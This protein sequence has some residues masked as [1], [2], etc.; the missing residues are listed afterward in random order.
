MSRKIKLHTFNALF[1]LF[2]HLADRTG[3]WR[4]FVRPKLL[5]GSLIVGLGLAI[6]KTIQAQNHNSSKKSLTDSIDSSKYN[7]AICYVIKAPDNV[8]TTKIY[9]VIDQMPLF[10]GGD[11][12][13]LNFI[14][15]NKRHPIVSCYENSISG[16]VICQFVVE[17]DGSISDISI[18]RSLDPTCDKEAMRVLKLLP[19]FIP[20]KQNGQ[21]VRVYYTIPIVFSLD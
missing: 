13:L 2:A 10:P 14:T 3:G 17:K 1:Q 7:G 18:I 6:P 12:E 21:A 19:K 15:K 11:D 16:K 5:L 4:V 9:T 20:G 8:D